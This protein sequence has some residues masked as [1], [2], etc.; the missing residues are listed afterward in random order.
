MDN[1][2]TRVGKIMSFLDPLNGERGKSQRIGDGQCVTE[3]ALKQ[4]EPMSMH[5]STTQAGI[6][7]ELVTGCGIMLYHQLIHPLGLLCVS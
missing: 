1:S 4:Q 5:P 3:T 6:E 2:N 7:Q